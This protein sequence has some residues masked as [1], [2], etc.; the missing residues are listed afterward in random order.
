MPAVTT[1]Q[2]LN[3]AA[4]RRL[5]DEGF[6][7]GDAGVVD[8]VCAADLN[9]HQDGFDAPGRDG[10]KKAITFLHALSPDIE[11]T[12]EE[13]DAADDR[14]WAR[15]RAHGTHGG[16]LMGGPSARAFDITV[17]DLC[18]FQDGRIVEHW[19]VPDRFAQFMQ[20]G[21]LQ[22]GPQQAGV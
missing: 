2:Q 19:G 20:L 15:L 22:V 9:E 5:I 18:R 17:M 10:V 8:D 21:L 11:I 14:V 12:V 1:E 16:S 13:I 6:S 4:F 7:G 3:L